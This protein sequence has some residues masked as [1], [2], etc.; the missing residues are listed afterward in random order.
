MTWKS[1]FSGFRGN[2]VSLYGCSMYV[3][4]YFKHYFYIIF[5]YVFIGKMIDSVNDRIRHGNKGQ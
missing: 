1:Y 5:I 4:R 2:P 3:N